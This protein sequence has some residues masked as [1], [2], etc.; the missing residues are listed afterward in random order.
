MKMSYPHRYAYSS[1][2]LQA[3]CLV[4]E[5]EDNYTSTRNVLYCQVHCTLFP[6]VLDGLR[7]YQP[8]HYPSFYATAFCNSALK[9]FGWVFSALITDYISFLE[10]HNFFSV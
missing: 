3:D 8:K 2:S 1:L 6:L 5:I 4:Y 9:L 7:G 10:V